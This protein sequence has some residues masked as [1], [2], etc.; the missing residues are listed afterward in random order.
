MRKLLLK[1]GYWKKNRKYQIEKNNVAIQ[2]IN[3]I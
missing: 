2:L 3:E 1:I